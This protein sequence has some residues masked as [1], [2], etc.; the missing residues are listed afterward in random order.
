MI[1]EIEVIVIFE[2]EEEQMAVLE[3]PD[4]STFAVK[5]DTLPPD[6]KPGES[7][8]VRDDGSFEILPEETRKRQKK[9]QHL[10]DSLWE[11]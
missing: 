7:L 11:K 6:A 2:R 9:V 5:R 4:G 8:L 3:R 1:G 10:L